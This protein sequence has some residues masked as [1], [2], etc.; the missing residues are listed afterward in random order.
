M[1]DGRRQ[2]NNFGSESEELGSNLGSVSYQLY[3]LGQGT[4]PLHL[5]DLIY[6]M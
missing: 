6:R 5:S 2:Y 4:S 3:N 1:K